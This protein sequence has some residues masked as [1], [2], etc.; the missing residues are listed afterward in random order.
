MH[1]AFQD[2]DNL[3]LAMDY[4]SGG[5]LRFHLCLNK[6]KFNEPQSK[7]FISCLL[8]S[9]EYLHYNNIIHRDIKPEN[10]VID[11]NGYLYLTDMGIARLYRKD[12]TIIDTSG[13]PGYMAPEVINNKNHD[14]SADYFAIGVMGFEFM[15][16]RVRKVFKL[17]AIFG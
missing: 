5:D 8:L 4:L 13:T 16:G 2:R 10:L 11:Q 9:L 15:L 14:L 1:Y 3:F 17:E 7:F 6:K 12:K